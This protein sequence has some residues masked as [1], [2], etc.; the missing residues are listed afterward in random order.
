M[1]KLLF[2]AIASMAL[3]SA[4]KKKDVEKTTAEK[5]VG[6]WKVSNFSFNDFNNNL[7]HFTS[8]TG[9]S[10]DYWDFRT[11]GKIYLQ[12][13]GVKDTVLYSI[14]SDTKMVYDG[15]DCDIRTLTDNQLVIYNKYTETTSPLRYYESTFNLAK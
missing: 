13:L 14:T 6:V 10:S 15:D 7:N 1:K 12:E 9:I 2:V 3:F 5:V 11:D 8:Y 4:C